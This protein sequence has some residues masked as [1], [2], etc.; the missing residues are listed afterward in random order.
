MSDIVMPSFSDSMQSGTVIKWLKSDGE[1]VAVGEDLVEIETDKAT[2]TYAAEVEGLL[3]IVAAEGTTVA[4]GEIMARTGVG[5]GAP[6]TKP[7]TTTADSGSDERDS[8]EMP[9]PNGNGAS[10]SGAA[11]A[12]VATP[13]ARRVAFIH[14]VDVRTLRGS[15]P[16]GRI[17]RRDVLDAAGVAPPE[18]P[19]GV[20]VRESPRP[21]A[22]AD[23]LP[24]R[25]DDDGRPIQQTRLQTL[26]AQRMVTSRTTIPEFEVQTDV[27]IDEAVAL[28][29][30]L[31]QLG[32]GQPVP[33]LNDFVIKAAALAL[34]RHP[35]VN[36]S[37]VDGTAR[38]HDHVNVGI[39]VATDDALIVP[40][41]T[42]ADVK[43]LGR[44]AAETRVCA[45]RVRDGSISPAE[46]EGGTFTVSNLGM[47]GMTA[48]RPVI[49]A[50]QVA[51][52]GV[53]AARPQLARSATGQ[54][55]DHTAMTLTVSADHRV[56]YGADAAA[57]LSHVK[58]LLEAPLRLAY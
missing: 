7:A 22:R 31:K 44:I 53:G 32:D 55:V 49:N 36:A 40:V 12:A 29:A 18:P 8:A 15:G 27:V 41:V 26:I 43:T 50:P 56:L 19:S 23:D 52:L 46:L 5:N 42:D 51:I 3:E 33:S 30:S 39:A 45:E 11:G 6:R 25:E 14:G 37:F 34:R 28:R 10:V 9:A 35:R 4:V 21:V 2:M 20:P 57:F 54:I 58:A 17:T 1:H 24:A 38:R 13:L 16:R 48:I 47:F